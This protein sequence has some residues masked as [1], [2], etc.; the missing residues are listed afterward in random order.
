[1]H[2]STSRWS[3]TSWDHVVMVTHC[4]IFQHQQVEHHFMR[5][6]SYCGALGVF[7]QQTNQQWTEHY[8][9]PKA[10]QFHI[11]FTTKQYCS[12]NYRYFMLNVSRPSDYCSLILKLHSDFSQHTSLPDLANLTVL[13]HYLTSSFCFCVQKIF[14]EIPG[15]VYKSSISVKF[16]LWTIIKITFYFC[17]I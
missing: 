13:M 9:Q 12:T 14:I 11:V 17:Q 16:Q 4:F 8:L 7:V 10:T 2:F 1:M 15:K 6:G 3:I 5:Y